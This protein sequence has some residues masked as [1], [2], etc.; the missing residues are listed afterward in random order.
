MKVS[1]IDVPERNR[2]EARDA[3]GARVGQVDYRRTDRQITF[4]HAEVD[5]SVEGQGVGSTLARHVLD[6]ARADDA[7]VVPA[8]PFI[9]EW[10]DR[11]PDYRDLVGG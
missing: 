4:T 5:P 7:S 6:R 9:E 10:I 11:H 1:V 3:N 8:C 2:Y